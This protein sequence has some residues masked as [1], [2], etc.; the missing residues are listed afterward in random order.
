[1]NKL[2][3]RDKD[4]PAASQGLMY[5]SVVCVIL[6]GIGALGVDLYLASTQWLLIGVTLIG[7]S[8]YMLL[9]AH[10]RLK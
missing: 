5:G 1:M 6:A 3:I 4:K 8:I 10:F 7:W 9:E 2:F